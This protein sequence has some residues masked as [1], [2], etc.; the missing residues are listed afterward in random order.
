MTRIAAVAL[1]ALLAAA[2]SAT[3][4]PDEEW[5]TSTRS[6]S[7]RIRDNPVGQYVLA[8]TVVSQASSA[9]D[10]RAL[11][12]E[13]LGYNLLQYCWTAENVLADWAR[14][15][16]LAGGMIV[17][18][19]ETRSW[20]R[21]LARAGYAAVPVAEAIG[22]YEAM[23]VAAEFTDAARAHAVERLAV[24]LRELRRTVPGAADIQA[25][26]RCRREDRS[27]ELGYRTVPENGRARFIP[28]LLH[29]ICQAQQLDPWD[30]VR[31]DYW[32]NGRTDGSMSVVGETNYAVR[33]PDGT[34]STGRFDAE[35]ARSAGTVTLRSRPAKTR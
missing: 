8:K 32:M 1:L 16:G 4:Q 26:D 24:D 13:P 12:V 3:A 22:R 15:A 20:Q 23:V 17:T 28:A 2:S 5:A 19:L 11:P 10:A 33:W 34:T 30:P 14:R 29:R 9:V 21:D 27:L 35:Q 25:S 7:E 6:S 31:C 18:A